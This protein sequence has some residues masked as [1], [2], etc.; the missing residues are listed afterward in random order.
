VAL[1]VVQVVAMHMWGQPPS[2]VRRAKLDCGLTNSKR[3]FSAPLVCRRGGNPLVQL[4]ANLFGGNGS[5]SLRIPNAFINGTERFLVSFVEN[6]SGCFEVEFLSFRHN[7]SIVS[8][9]PDRCK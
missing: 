4:L 9:V 3:L 7:R 8:W 5:A 2:A 1:S 6:G